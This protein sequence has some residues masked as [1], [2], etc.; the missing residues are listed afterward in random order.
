VG[1]REDD[2]GMSAWYVTAARCAVS[3]ILIGTSA[4]DAALAQSST[5]AQ[6]WT[7]TPAG[8]QIALGDRPLS[9]AS[10][11]D[12]RTLLVGNDG[13]STQSLMVVDR[14]SGS[15][16][17]TIAYPA[18]EALFV[19]LVFSP[20]GKHAYASAGGNNKIRTYAVDG[21][22]LAEGESV[23]LPTVK[24]GKKI[25]LYPAGLAIAADG[26]TLF[27][28][29]N[30][31]D[32]LSLVD[33]PT[34]TVKA[35][36][37]VGH[38]PYGALLSDDGK[39]VYISNW[40]EQSV[41]VADAA[42]AQV[43]QKITVGTHPSALALSSARHELYVA[44]SDSDSISVIDTGTNQLVRT[45]SLAPYENAPH[46]ASPNGLALSGDTLY[47]ANA[48]NNNVAVIQLGAPDQI[49]GL[50]PTA[51]Y[52]TAVAV[53][54]AGDQL[55]VV[56][57]KGLGAGPNQNG[58]DPYRPNTPADQYVGSM[59]V[60]SLSFISVPDQAALDVLTKQV[61]ANN[62]FD[63]PAQSLTPGQ[64]IPRRPGDPSPIKHIIYVIRENRTFDQVLGSLGKGNGDASL[65]LF[66]DASAPNT[67]ELARR[68]VTLDNF[69]ADAEVSA[70]GWNWSTA[71]EANT[72]VQK[73]W[74][75]N[76]SSGRNRPYDFEGGNLA[77]AP[78]K[79]PDNAYLWDR[80]E[81]GGISYRNYGFWIFG[82]KIASTAPKLGEH[83][84]LN[85]AGYDLAVS[86]QTRLDEWL[87]EFQQFQADSNLPTVQLVRLP[88][89]H[90]AGT[91][92]NSPTPRA[93][94]ADNDLALGR[95]VDA[96]SHS[97]FWPETAIC[98]LEDDAQNGPDHVDAHRTVALIVSPY[99]QTGAVDSTFYS[100][101]S[102]L[103]TIE[104]IVGLPPMTQF[105]A[106]ATP[107][108][109]S[110][111]DTPNLQPYSAVVPDQ[112]LDEVNTAASP[113]SAKSE[114]MDFT[115]E[116]RAPEQA[117]NEAIWQSVRG[118]D[119]VMPEAR[120]SFRAAIHLGPAVADDD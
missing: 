39:S 17:Q 71:A 31:D 35:T 84:D 25:N 40:G 119:S 42:T 11:P 27:V 22:Q 120:T 87:T 43:R 68:F 32:S 30:L 88:N 14:E 24:D 12:G 13:Q 77:T 78:G 19:G 82:G 93:Y 7:L 118:V 110:F 20:D 36:F 49:R 115:A 16:K 92:P 41:S 34:R 59:A 96:V 117:L 37:P 85:F 94:M 58:P 1:F 29:N 81:A 74:P 102:M 38:N 98:V 18:P 10:S 75:A 67:R 65:N 33:L 63:Q 89:D 52:P 4:S 76:Y 64:V 95:L 72:Y 3:L 62:R 103:R 45:I 105:D 48:G 26:N 101:S 100:T 28:A 116:D 113:M 83:S 70:D 51:W 6:G 79:T 97:T 44:N 86:D 50:I 114:A 23:M 108:L 99:T 109:A 46:G 21:Q 91:R 90:T 112:P 60:G 111:S 61:V 47:V 8:R 5:S 66:D 107:M 55:Y 57:A 53:S 73:T 15:V 2:V 54:P 56:N 104:L 9:I 80:L 106:A 69:Y